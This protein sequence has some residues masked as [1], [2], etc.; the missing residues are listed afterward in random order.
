MLTLQNKNIVDKSGS[1]VLFLKSPLRLFNKI[2]ELSLFLYKLKL[3]QSPSTSSV[4]HS[5]RFLKKLIL[6]SDKCSVQ[7]F[8]TLL[9]ETFFSE[10][11][12]E[13]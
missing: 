3:M 5:F 6:K 13:T 10:I 2:I 12:K 4:H 1:T 7:T 8:K 11:N 9:I